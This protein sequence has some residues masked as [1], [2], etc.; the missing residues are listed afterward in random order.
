MPKLLASPTR[1]D[2]P[3]RKS[4]QEKSEFGLVAH[5]NAKVSKKKRDQQK[6]CTMQRQLRH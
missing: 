4:Q 6:S 1:K 3:E 2:P 5:L